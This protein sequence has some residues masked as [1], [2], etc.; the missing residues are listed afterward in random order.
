MSKYYAE[1]GL[2]HLGDSKNCFKMIKKTISSGVD[3]ITLQV[4]PKKY[5]NNSRPFRREL[6]KEF[7]KKVSNYLKKK[8]ID[9]G[10]AVT[11]VEVVKNFA[12]IRV[13][14]WKV[15][16]FEFFNT[17][18]LKELKKKNKKIYL[19][20]G[21]ASMRDIKNTSLKFKKFDFIHTTL[22]SKINNANIKAIESMKKVLK[23]KKISFSLHAKEDGV[24]ISAITLGADPIFFYVKNKDKK[25]Y[26][27]SDHAIN[28]NHLKE[29]INFWKKLKNL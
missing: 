28:L 3:G 8:R 1:I 11:D 25:F 27:D 12:D 26:P 13:D 20:T 9:F 14:F 19:S 22:S 10:L 23:N 18:L 7:Y 4:W 24:I 17:G 6:S 5:Y 15:L 29:K 21:V 2:N 16:S